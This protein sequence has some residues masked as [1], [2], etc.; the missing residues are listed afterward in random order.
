MRRNYDDE[1]EEY[2]T[3]RPQQRPQTPQDRTRAWFGLSGIRSMQPSRLA[4]V[5]SEW[6]L[7]ELVRRPGD[8]SRTTATSLTQREPQELDDRA[9][10]AGEWYGGGKVRQD[11]GRRNEEPTH[12]SRGEQEEEFRRKYDD[13]EQVLKHTEDRTDPDAR[14]LRNR[15]LTAFTDG[16][17]GFNDRRREGRRHRPTNDEELTQGPRAPHQ[18]EPYESMPLQRL[19]SF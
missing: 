5:D 1:A 10:G 17:M 18:P 6:L 2:E 11:V 9:P 13:F 3:R 12:Y 15:L 7:G 19:Y 16:Y 14:Y 8:N 4:G